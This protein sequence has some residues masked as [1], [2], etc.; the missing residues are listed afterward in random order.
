MQKLNLS[1]NIKIP[2]RN[3]AVNQ[4]NS[5]HITAADERHLANPLQRNSQRKSDLLATRH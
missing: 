4:S 5:R 2:I 1:K 3:A